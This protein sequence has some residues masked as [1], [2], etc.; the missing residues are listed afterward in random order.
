MADPQTTMLRDALTSVLSP[1]KVRSEARRTGAVKRQRSVNIFALVCTLVLGFQDGAARS[2]AGLRQAYGLRTGVNLAPSAFYTRL[3]RALAKLM[4][5]LV[6]DALSGAEVGFAL[7]SGALAGFHDL[8]AIDATV[9]RLHDLLAGTYSA[10][11]TNHT[12]AAA[13]LHMVMSVV[14]GSPHSVKLT[15]ERVSDTT[16]WRRVGKWVRGS[17]LLFELGYYSFHLFDRIDANGGFFL[18]RAKSNANPRIIAVNRK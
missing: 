9:L 3:S 16:P 14:S 8:L 11:R 4:R 7:P 15:A 5:R 13:K 2:I 18:S 10:C 17:L 12:E 6:L 1:E